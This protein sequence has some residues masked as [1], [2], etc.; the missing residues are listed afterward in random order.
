MS[1]RLGV[2]RSVR[3]KMLPPTSVNTPSTSPVLRASFSRLVT[4][5]SIVSKDIPGSTVTV[6]RTWPS[7]IFGK[8]AWRSERK[9]GIATANA[10]TIGTTV[11]HGRS[12]TFSSTPAYQLRA[13]SVSALI[14]SYIKPLDRVGMRAAK[15]GTR[16]KATTREA[17]IAAEIVKINS[18]NNSPTRPEINRNGN[19]ADRLVLVD[20][21]IALA[22]S[23]AAS[24]E[25][26]CGSLSGSFCLCRV[27]FSSITIVLSINIPT[28]S[29]RPPS[30]ITLRVR[31]PNAMMTNVTRI[32]I[33][34]AVPMISVPRTFPRN[35]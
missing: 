15:D 16:V 24:D 2:S 35:A 23:P 12:R 3:P 1:L 19:T 33:G 30:V 6:T 10:R 28:P 34:I 4:V 29:A 8:N 20:A 25:V 14:F 18:R 9:V 32:E 11:I 27:M 22:T 26:S 5:E 7:S 21:R 31:P 17:T 13:R